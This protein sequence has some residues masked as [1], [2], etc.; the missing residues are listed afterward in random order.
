MSEKLLENI[1]TVLSDPRTTETFYLL[2]QNSKDEVA[3]E[4]NH[5]N[6]GDIRHSRSQMEKALRNLEKADLAERETAEY[7]EIGEIVV[8]EFQKYVEELRALRYELSDKIEQK[9]RSEPLETPEYGFLIRKNQAQSLKG[10]LPSTI[11]EVR[12]YEQAAEA[13][14]N[15]FD[16]QLRREL[17]KA[18]DSVDLDKIDGSAQKYFKD[19]KEKGMIREDEDVVDYFHPTKFMDATIEFNRNLQKAVKGYEHVRH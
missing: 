17:L 5:N 14:E 4:L 9:D 15:I 19:F 6:V 11:D 18:E 16:N 10:L 7:T 8:E 1:R 13:A 2:D 12:T 3:E